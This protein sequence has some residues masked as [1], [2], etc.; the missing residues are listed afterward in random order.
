MSYADIT[1]SAVYE[2]A[3]QIDGDCVTMTHY[4]DFESWRLKRLSNALSYAAGCMSRRPDIASSM[5]LSTV[6]RVHDHK[7][8]LSILWRTKTAALAYGSL[9]AAAWEFVG[10]LDEQ[11]EHYVADDTGAVPIYRGGDPADN[12]AEASHW[13]WSHPF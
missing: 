8:N 13:D 3:S 12:M 1:G 11:V 6:I 7:G 5:F 4:N 10:E 2:Y 9:M